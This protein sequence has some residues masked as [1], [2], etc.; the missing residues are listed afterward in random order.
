MA[1]H[2]FLP[3]G[4]LHRGHVP[5]LL[6]ETLERLAP[7]SGAIYMD[8]TFGSGGVSRALLARAPCRV[9]AIDRD[10]TALADA[11]AIARDEGERFRFQVGRIGTLS[12]CAA[13]LGAPIVDG[14][15]VF[16]LGVS[17][18]QLDDP[19]RGF[20]FRHD[21][22]LDMRM[23]EGDLT[24][25]D[26]VNES[27]EGKL[28]RILRDFGEERRARRV[29]R[30][31][32]EE[33]DRAPFS[34][35]AALAD[36]VR[37]VVP[38]RPGVT[39]PATRTFQALR[40]AVN[41]ELGELQ[42]GLRDA[43]RVLAKGARLVVI[44]FHSLEDRIVKRFLALRSGRSPKPSRYLPDRPTNTPSFR[45]LSRRPVRPSV[46]EVAANPRSRSARL[47]SAERTEAPAMVEAP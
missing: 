27:D 17:S 7:R 39:D 37:R 19:A 6:A 38:F 23:G 36:L 2:S 32:V 28:A 33:R 35:T 34:H 44:S 20:S 13:S 46:E 9:V 1:T 41:D 26:I 29:A 10:P 43:E 47:R 24:A 22:P 8:S 18:R 30:A 45:L 11:N 31:I 14:G 12:E 15:I 3:D 42:K 16:D 40:I 21:G 4:L 25:A 5:V